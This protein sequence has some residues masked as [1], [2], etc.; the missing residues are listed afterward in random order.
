MKKVGCLVGAGLGAFLLL[1]VFWGMETFNKLNRLDQDVKEA[2][3]QV[4]NVY[5]RRLDL[6]PNMVE[7]VKR[8]AKHEQ[9]IFKDI[10]EAR[11]RYAG[12]APASPA[13]M[14]KANGELSSFFS[15]LMVIVENYPNLKANEQ[16]GRLM[17]QW[18]GSEN[19]ISTERRRFNEMV[20]TYNYTA[21]SFMGRIW[22]SLFKFDK[23]KQYFKAVEGAEKAPSAK[24]AFGDD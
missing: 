1:M 20:K 11:T 6:L 3:S 7:V 24:D 22:V 13:E 17:D 14:D 12:K 16:F 23:E 9:K 15:R 18:E 19:R 10:A 5:Q 8:Y 21:K 2:W 4:E